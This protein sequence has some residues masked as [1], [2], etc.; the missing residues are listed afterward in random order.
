MKLF[1]K[2]GGLYKVPNSNYWNIN[3]I[4]K[5]LYI[6][7]DKNYFGEFNDKKYE[8]LGKYFVM[9]ILSKSNK[10]INLSMDDLP[11]INDIQ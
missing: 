2:D 11:N 9:Q 6:Y 7:N 10:Q 8:E 3:L 5:I 1:S 4:D